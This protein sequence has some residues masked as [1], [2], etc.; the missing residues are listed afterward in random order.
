MAAHRSIFL[1]LALLAGLARAQTMY[2]TDEL[3]ITLRTGPSTQNTIIENL[4]SGDRVEVLE[5]D[6]ESGYARVRVADGGEEGWVLSRFLTAE[7]TAALEL[8]DTSGSLSA[9]NARIASLEQEVETLR[10]G[11]DTSQAKLASTESSNTSLT[12]QLRDVR[13]AS[14]SA[15]ET[16]EQNESLRR[17]NNELN[18]QLEDLTARNTALAG[19]S[20]QNWFVV[21][22]LVL[23]AGVVIGLIAPSLRRKRRSSW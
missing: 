21:G 20:D 13:S 14:A 1:C 18:Q 19:R 9:A 23:V 6:P 4:G 3:V 15:I 2:V 10:E 8:V 16:R 17:R 22:A 12:T 7:R 11:L 5:D